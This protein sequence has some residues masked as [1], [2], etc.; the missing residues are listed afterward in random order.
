MFK[1][2]DVLL[3]SFDFSFGIFELFQKFERSFVSFVNFFFEFKNII[4][5]VFDFNLKLFFLIS[6]LTDVFFGGLV[7]SMDVLL[8]FDGLLV[9]KD[10]GFVLKFGGGKSGNFM[11]M[12]SDYL[13]SRNSKLLVL[14]FES[15]KS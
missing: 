12:L 15:S 3:E 1:I 13:S 11:S 6:Q 9:T 10:G 7:L 5:Q 8:V 4:G 14:V 2:N